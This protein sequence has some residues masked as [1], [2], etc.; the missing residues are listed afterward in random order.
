[1]PA[2][3]KASVEL[4]FGQF[5][6]YRAAMPERVE[7]AIGAEAEAVASDWAGK[8][9]VHSGAYRD[10]IQAAQ[11]GTWQWAAYSDIPYAPENE[12]GG[13]TISA[14]PDATQTGEQHRAPFL[15][16]VAEALGRG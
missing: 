8:V 14:Q 13:K 5:D 9:R 11:L 16:R 15:D 4:N 2:N 3:V 12:Y 10:S 1:M 7:T 6:G